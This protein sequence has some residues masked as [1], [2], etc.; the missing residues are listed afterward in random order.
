MNLFEKFIAEVKGTE[1][2]SGTDYTARVVK[3][4]GKHVAKFFNRGEH[5]KDA[6]Y[7]GEDEKDAH[8]FA[9]DEMVH[10]KSQVSERI[11]NPAGREIVPDKITD[12]AVEKRGRVKKMMGNRMPMEIIARI[13][14]KREI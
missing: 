1:Y 9:K 12:G 3:I 10:R 6:D 8:E 4:G 5:M 2:K 7:E 11:N 13:L 14:S